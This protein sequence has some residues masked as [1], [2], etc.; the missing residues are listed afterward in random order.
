MIWDL[1]IGSCIYSWL[2]FNNCINTIV[3]I[4]ENIIAVIKEITGTILF[5]NVN[6]KLYLK[7]TINLPKVRYVNTFIKLN[8]YQF[9]YCDNINIKMIS[10][11]MNS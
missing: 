1:T 2:N 10:I 9:V 6:N 11:N 8:A 5:W 3:K 4:N 7:T